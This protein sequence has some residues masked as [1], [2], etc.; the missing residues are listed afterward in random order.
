MVL[1]R[2]AVR[3]W[4]Q[5][6]AA[7]HRLWTEAIVAQRQAAGLPPP[8]TLLAVS[9]GVDK[10]AFSAGILNA[11]TRRGGRPSF[12]IVTGV[13]TGALIAPFAFLGAEEDDELK[14]IY[15]NLKREDI[16]RQKIL[17]GLLGGSSL[18]DTAPLKT[19]IAQHVTPAFLARIAAEHGKGRRLLVMT[20]NLDAQRGV[21]WDMGAIAG[22]GSPRALVLFRDVLLA[23]A[24]IPGAFPPVLIDVTGNGRRFAEMHVDGGTVGG[25]FALPRTTLLLNGNSQSRT[26]I[27]LLY[28]GTLAPEFTVAKPRILSILSRSLAV[29]LGEADRN[30]LEELR[31]FARERDASLAICAIAE[32]PSEKAPPLFDTTH[33]RALYTLGEEQGSK[34]DGCLATSH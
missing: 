30:I 21:I 18:L 34:A 23:S 25:F 9:G 8:R 10:G 7:R 2:S 29:S 1:E 4:A 16:Y 17:S 24:S 3:L 11:W 28:N 5:N 13:S 27:Y 15:T 6:D 22:S 26:A 33:M 32:E 19:L 12:D 31:T 20:T 14:A